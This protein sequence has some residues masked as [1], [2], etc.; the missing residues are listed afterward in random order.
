MP[1]NILLIMTDQQRLDH[2]GFAPGSKVATPNIDRI[3]E[4]MGFTNCSTTNPVC[5]PARS[6]LLTGRYTHQIGMLAMSGDLS[7]EIPTYPQALQ[8]T[9]YFTAG[10]GK[11][12]WLQGWHWEREFGKGHPLAAMKDAMKRYGFDAIWE[13]SGKQLLLRNYCDYAAHLEKKGLLG[14]FREIQIDSMPNSDDPAVQPWDQALVWPFAEKDHV[15]IMTADKVLETLDHRPQDKPFFIFCSFCSPHRP[16]DPPQRYLDQVP[17]EEVDDFIPGVVPLSEETKKKL[18]RFRQYYRALI[19]L[20]DEQVGRIF[21]RLEDLNLLDDTVILFTTDH[22]EMMG[23]HNRSEK[24]CAYRESVTVPTA[25]RHPDYLRHA[26][27]D[28][29]IELTDLTATILD[30]AGLDPQ[31]ALATPWPFGGMAI[32][33]RSLLPLLRGEIEQLRELAFAE[34]IGTHLTPAGRSPVRWEMATSQRYKYIRFI[35]LFINLRNPS[36][37]SYLQE[38]F[39]DLFQD[40]QEQVNLIDQP[41]LQAV[42]ERCRRYCQFVNDLTPP[43]Q[44]RWAPIIE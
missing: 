34:G 10:I 12:H 38:E 30:V 17:Y 33:G 40:P 9:G 19:R 44:T 8:R 36:P 13:T 11:F 1:K 14:A 31:A 21:A 5:T 24:A 3:A 37:E 42:I 2:T 25:I 27:T 43:V 23:D 4:G 7:Q 16:F 20:I 32:P 29:P 15:D 35:D 28:T 26:I 39:F 6:A 22:G 18:Y 41:G